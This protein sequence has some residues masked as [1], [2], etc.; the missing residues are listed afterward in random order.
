MQPYA[1]WTGTPKRGVWTAVI[2]DADHGKVLWTSPHRHPTLR[3][4]LA[5]AEAQHAK[6]SK[7]KT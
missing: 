4:A 3:E 6:L 1:M 5:E 2:K 7:E